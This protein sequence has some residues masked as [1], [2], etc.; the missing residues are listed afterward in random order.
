MT[1]WNYL[2]IT[3]TIL[4]DSSKTEIESIASELVCSQIA[5]RYDNYITLKF[6]IILSFYEIYFFDSHDPDANHFC[7]EKEKQICHLMKEFSTKQPFSTS[8]DRSVPC[9]SRHKTCLDNGIIQAF[10]K[11][12][13]G[14]YSFSSKR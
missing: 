12:Q 2:P 5:K 9:Y 3:P 8:T 10:V 6:V 11:E 4:E 1:R 7:Y 13:Q 14:K